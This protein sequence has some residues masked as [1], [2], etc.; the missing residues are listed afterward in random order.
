MRFNNSLH[1]YCNDFSKTKTKHISSFI[2][3]HIISK[4]YC[5]NVLIFFLQQDHPLLILFDYIHL[6]S[7]HAFDEYYSRK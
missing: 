5:S 3:V 1:S 6:H 7:L 2:S 4:V